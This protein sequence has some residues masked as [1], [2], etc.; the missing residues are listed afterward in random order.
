VFRAS[1][2]VLTSLVGLAFTPIA[3]V[4]S[5]EPFCVDG[6]AVTVSGITSIPLT[7]GHEVSTAKAPA[8]LFFADGSSVKLAA[9]SRAKLVG[10]EAQPKLVLLAG[11]LDYKIVLGSNLSVTSL[12][13]ERTSK[14][15]G[16]AIEQQAQAKR[17]SPPEPR[18]ATLSVVTH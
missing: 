1:L 14:V 8:V 15:L 11:S 5:D 10:S 3:T 7:V 12:D 4:T 17:V 2:F 18:D 16:R 6:R 13:L 9:S